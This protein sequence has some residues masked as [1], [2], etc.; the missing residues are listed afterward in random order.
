MKNTASHSIY[1]SGPKLEFELNRL[2]RER[3]E[4][5]EVEGRL[6]ER[7]Q[8][9]AQCEEIQNKLA[10]LRGRIEEQAIEEFNAY[11]ERDLELLDYTN[12]TRIWLECRET[13]LRKVTKSVSGLHVTRSTDSS[14]I[15]K[16]TIDHLSE[17]EREFPVSVFGLAGYLAH[18]H[19]E[20]IPI[21]LLDSLEIID[22]IGSRRSSTTS[23]TTP[24]TS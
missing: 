2:Q 21:M 10:D 17:S 22:R 13:Q 15:Y 23:A 11:M 16:D 19:Y 7:K 20:S 4:I 9:D 1:S 18:Y 12:I 3:E 8:L 14:A 24:S 6:A 5:K